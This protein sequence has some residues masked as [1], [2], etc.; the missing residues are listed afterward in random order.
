[1]SRI[2]DHEIHAFVDGELDAKDAA[3]IE[4]A[5]ADDV[6]V[7]ARVERERRLRGQLQATFDPVLAEPVPDRL[8]AMLRADDRADAQSSIVRGQGT[9]DATDRTVVPMR[10]RPQR[11]RW[12]APVYALAASL[13][14][15]AVTNWIRPSASPIELHDGAL[16][17]GPSLQRELDRALASEPDDGAS[18]AIGLTFRDDGGRICRSFVER[19]A[20]IAGLACREDAG[21]RLP[22]VGSIDADAGGEIRQAAAAMP[23][24]VQA[25]IDARLADDPF[26]AVQER[27]AQAAGWR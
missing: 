18:V 20:A 10:A 2:E 11:A 5:M 4:A 15:L 14:V 16:V 3:R 25:E 9:G 8:L 21:W 19:D 24:A 1:M 22:V 13:A 23:A 12:H 7:A 17:A 6:L 26:D 27:E